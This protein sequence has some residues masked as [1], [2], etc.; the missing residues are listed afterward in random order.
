MAA[1]AAQLSTP[2]AEGVHSRLDL[3]CYSVQPS[4]CDHSSLPEV[5][6]LAQC[7]SS[8]CSTAVQLGLLVTQLLLYVL[9]C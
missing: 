8:G 7:H 1:T 9:L 5:L 3:S 6:T 4:C 2:A